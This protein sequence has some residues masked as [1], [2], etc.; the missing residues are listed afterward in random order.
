MAENTSPTPVATPQGTYKFTVTPSPH[1]KAPFN[2]RTIMYL[3]ILA[4]MPALV[5]AVYFYGFWSLFLVLISVATAVGSE[6]LMNLAFKRPLADS[7]DGS[8]IITGLL[9]AYNVPPSAPWWMVAAG[10]AF[11]IIVAKAF[12]GGL[13]HNFLNPA[14]TGRAFLMASWPTLMTSGWLIRKGLGTVSGVPQSMWTSVIDAVKSSPSTIHG[15]DALTGATPLGVL[16]KLKIATDPALIS[17]TKQVLNDPS[18]IKSLF[19][20]NVGGVIGETS[21][22]LLL[23]PALLLMVIR[24][25]DWRVPLAYIATTA[26]ISLAAYLFGAT[27][28]TPI[29]HLCAGGLMLGALFMA[30]DYSTTPVTPAGQW[31]FG[32]GCGII[33]MLI[34]L[35]GGYPEGVSYSILLM[36]VATPLIDRFTRPRILGEQRKRKG[37]K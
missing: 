10:S 26:A 1:F 27:P 15:V 29:Y 11:A 5:G 9:L 37:A 36:N 7:L 4:L 25:I 6:F 8:A 30:T 32:V 31:I 19:W 22:I 21:V 2:V 24:V 28:V 14:L 13:G 17:G 23:V 33:T 3:V 12:F 18:V 34:R 16:Q 20:G 35:W